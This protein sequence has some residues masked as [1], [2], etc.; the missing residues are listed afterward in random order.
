[1]SWELVSCT[2]VASILFLL[3]RQREQ[4][5]AA[6][7]DERDRMTALANATNDALLVV[8]VDG[9]IT[10]ANAAA[11]RIFGYPQAELIGMN[12]LALFDSDG[13]G[14][15]ALS[16]G[17]EDGGR[18]LL[19]LGG[20]V[21]GRAKDGLQLPLLLGVRDFAAGG[22]RQIA[23]AIRDA[24]AQKRVDEETRR[25][26]DQLRLTKESLQRHNI[27]LEQTIEQRTEQLRDAKEAAEVANQAKSEFL[28]NMSHELRTPLHG[29]LSFARFGIKRHATVTPQ[30]VHEYFQQIERSGATLLNIL[31]ELLDLAKLESGKMQF[32]FHRLDIVELAEEALGEF[33]AICDDRKLTSRLDAPS[34]P[35]MADV[36]RLRITQV[37][38][39]LLSNA[40]KFSPDGGCVAVTIS[41]AR[42]EISLEVQDE[43]PGIPAAELESVFDKFVQSSRTK[44]G[45]G[46]TGLGLAICREIVQRHG[47]RVWCENSAT[48]GAAF[49]IV[50]PQA[51]RLPIDA[52]DN[53]S[54]AGSLALAR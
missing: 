21:Q 53:E 52:V 19:L 17:L 54:P 34:Q 29:I 12:V 31:N 33:R 27:L 26:T 48:G 39:N 37:L 16:R 3:H 1:M 44:T 42:S 28:A 36:D 30:K 18:W 15:E 7:R 47:G 11:S 50:L 43:G 25:Y 24:T 41:A 14:R 13:G 6:L 10:S 5:Q 38:R 23:L 49:R 2:I 32:E 4:A 20:E 22:R 46:G 45:A 9:T 40:V 35:L 51:E 8:E